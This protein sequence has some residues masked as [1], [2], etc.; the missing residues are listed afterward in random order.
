[1]GDVG[2]YKGGVIKLE[3]CKGLK[4]IIC[5]PKEFALYIV[6]KTYLKVII[7]FEI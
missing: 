3:E 7:S 2:R 6:I 5:L 1:M 4:G